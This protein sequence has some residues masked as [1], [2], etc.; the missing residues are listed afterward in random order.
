MFLQYMNNA[1]VASERRELKEETHG[2]FGW[3]GK[4]ELVINLFV[5]GMRIE[6][7][8]NRDV[9]GSMEVEGVDLC[10]VSRERSGEE[11]FLTL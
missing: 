7:V 5:L 3:E 2:K 9:D 1:S 4:L 10:R 8:F 11:E 6:S